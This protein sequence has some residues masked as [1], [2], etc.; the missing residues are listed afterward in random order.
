[1]ARGYQIVAEVK[2]ESPFGFRSDKS[3]QELFDLAEALGDIISI[4]T[5]PRWG[6]SFELLKKARTLT[7]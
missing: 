5:D 7:L 4:H 6:G 3:W 2:T 1:M